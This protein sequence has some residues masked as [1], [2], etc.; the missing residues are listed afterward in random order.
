MKHNIQNQFRLE[1]KTALV[2]GGAGLLGKSHVEA[3]L[4]TG[5]KVVI[6]DNNEQ[7]LSKIEK[8]MG[9]KFS[10]NIFCFNANICSEESIKFVCDELVKRDIF[11]DILINNAAIDPKVGQ[12]GNILNNSRLENFSLEDWNL[13]LSVGLTGAYLCCKIFGNLMASKNGGVILNIA[14]DL[15]IIAP[16]QRLYK[17]EGI[18]SK[19]QPVKPVTYS[20]IKHGLIGLTKYIATYWKDANIRCNALSPGGIYNGQSKEFVD[21]LISRIPMGRMANIEEYKASIIYLCS[22]ASSYM[23]G[24]NIVIDGGRTIW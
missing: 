9:K 13:Q 21:A 12:K 20:V 11:V 15:S 7:S 10:K 1:G 2:T 17:V 23:T 4:E 18:K 8:S 14:S 3:L 6:I 22:D 16:D 24:Q 19:Y 5:A